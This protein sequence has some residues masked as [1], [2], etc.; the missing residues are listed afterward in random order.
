MPTV[1]TWMA[2][3]LGCTTADA[4]AII[5]SLPVPVNERFNC[6]A[7]NP[8]RFLG[9]ILA[10]NTN[11]EILMY[12]TSGMDPRG[13]DLLHGYAINVYT[14]GTLI[15]ASS[16]PIDLCERPGDCQHINI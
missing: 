9:F 10:A 14:T 15:H 1:S 6:N 13:R 12:E 8:M 3:K 4:K 16:V 11:P 7:Y 5:S 2:T